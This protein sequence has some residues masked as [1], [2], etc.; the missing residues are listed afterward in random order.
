MSECA[1]GIG[2]RTLRVRLFLLAARVVFGTWVLWCEL[3]VRAVVLTLLLVLVPVIVPLATFPAGRRLG[4]RL[5][6]TFLAVAA[7]KFLIV[8]TLSLGFDELLGSSAT[9]IITGAVTLMLATF[10][11]FT[12][13]K[14]IPFVETAAMH[15]LEGVASEVYEIG[16]GHLFVSGGP[17][18]RAMVPGA[19]FTGRGRRAPTT[20]VSKCGRARRNRPMPVALRREAGSTDRDPDAAWRSRG[21]PTRTR[22]VRSWAGTSMSDLARPRTSPTQRTVGSE[23]DDTRPHSRH[24]R[25]R[26]RR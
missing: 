11:P 26:I 16:Y 20:S 23:F 21:V 2:C 19:P 25:R 3:I 18:R 9:Q 17:G 7:S 13:L 15:N 8:I 24:R 5:A 12:L 10:S 14:L 1:H 22:W 4:W 6:E